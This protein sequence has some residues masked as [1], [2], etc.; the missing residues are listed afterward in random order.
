MGF[1]FLLS[2][3]KE[4]KGGRELFVSVQVISQLTKGWTSWKK[5]YMQS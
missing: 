2:E 4:E 3:F 1:V 5:E